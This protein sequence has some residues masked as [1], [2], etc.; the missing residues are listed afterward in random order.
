MSAAKDG[1]FQKVAAWLFPQP[2]EIIRT[3]LMR[4]QFER[5]RSQIP[6]LH[7]TGTFSMTLIL[8]LA[9]HDGAHW[10]TIAFLSAMP[11]FSIYRIFTWRRETGAGIP[12]ERLAAFLRRTTAIGSGAIALASGIAVYCY[13]AGISSEP[14]VIPLSLFFGIICVAFSFAPVPKAAILALTVGIVPAAIALILFGDLLAMMLAVSGLSVSLLLL[15]FIHEYFREI[16]ASLLLERQVREQATTDPLTGLLNRRGFDALLESML[17][18]AEETRQAL[19]LGFADLDNFKGINDRFGH[20]AGDEYLRVA[21][22]RFRQALP[23]GTVV[24]RLGGDEFGMILPLS[25]AES[26][27]D[28]I[29]NG[30]LDTVCRDI[31]LGPATRRISISVGFA[32]G[33]SSA[34]EL[35]RDADQALYEAKNAGKNRFFRYGQ[36]APARE[37][38]NSAA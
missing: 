5:M 8:W 18:Q 19:T 34:H 38:S 33:H 11:L 36:P 31:D 35:M 24:A 12:D 32:S 9:I 37:R 22:K 10:G 23:E 20:S 15:R 6:F 26:R 16:V 25:I 2:P 1:V 30:V 21:A 13:L 28:E 17:A 3:E 27:I 14:I 7:G 29:G 4:L